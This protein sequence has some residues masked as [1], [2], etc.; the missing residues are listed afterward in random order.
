MKVYCEIVDGYNINFVT[1]RD[2]FSFDIR[3]VD[4]KTNEENILKLVQ[5][6]KYK[7]LFIIEEYN[8]QFKIKPVSTFNEFYRVEP[9]NQDT[10]YRLDM[11]Y[12]L[13]KIIIKGFNFKVK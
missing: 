13:N 12:L 10:M 4:M 11:L 3:L 2:E 6:N 8:L 1:T 9:A 5:S 7:N